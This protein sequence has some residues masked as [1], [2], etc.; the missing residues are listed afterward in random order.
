LLNLH[1]HAEQ[2]LDDVR[3]GVARVEERREIGLGHETA[4]FEQRAGEA[5]ERVELGVR[6]RVALARRFVVK[7]KESVVPG[8]FGTEPPTRYT[9]RLF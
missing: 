7:L 3:P 2:Y 1:A 4:L 6:E 5:H 9:C 8:R